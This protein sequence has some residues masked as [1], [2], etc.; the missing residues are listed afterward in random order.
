MLGQTIA[1]Y[2]I[3]EKI[4][5]GGMGVVY[6]AEDQRLHRKTALKFLVPEFL[7]DDRAR[8]RFETEARTIAQLNHPNI[9][10]LYDLQENNGDYFLAME[11]V[12]G[13]T[14]RELLNDWQDNPEQVQSEWTRE[15][16][17][18][19]A[20][21]ICEGLQ[22]AHQHGIIHRDLKPENIIITP[23]GKLKILD[24]GLAKLNSDTVD[25]QPGSGSL[26]Y[27][28]PEQLLEQEATPQTDIWALG[29]ILYELI[30]GQRPFDGLHT[31]GIIYAISNEAP[32]PLESRVGD[33]PGGLN[34]LI[35]HCLEK[36]SSDRPA[37]I[38]QVKEALLSLSSPAG[39]AEIRTPDLQQPLKKHRLKIA[40]TVT[41]LLLGIMI[42]KAI[43]Y[44][45]IPEEKRIA[46]LPF[47][48]VDQTEENRVFGNGLGEYIS[49]ELT[50]WEN[51]EGSL[52]VVPFS[53]VRRL[54]IS[55]AG[56][57]R[58][59][60]GVNLAIGGSVQRSANQT[61]L[62]LNLIDVQ[63]MRQL[64]ST[65]IKDPSGNLAAL[66]SS[67]F[68]RIAEML[69]VELQPRQAVRVEQYTSIA[70]GAYEFYLLGRGYLMDYNRAENLDQAVRL[71]RQAIDKDHNYAAAFAGLGEA[72]WRKYQFSKDT[73]WVDLAVQN[74]QRAIALNS[75][76]VPGLITLGMIYR[77]TGRYREA[78]QTFQ[79]A[80]TIDPQ[81]S[82]AYQELAGA[83]SNLGQPEQVEQTYHKAIRLKPYYWA[84]YYDLGRF[85]YSRGDYSKAEEQF[86]TVISLTPKNYKVYRNLGGIYSLRERYGEA[87]KMLEKSIGIKPNYGAYSNL[88]ALFFIREEYRKAARMFEKALEQNDRYY[89]IWG[90][91]GV[92]YKMLSGGSLRAEKAFR[93]AIELAEAGL[94]VN[95]KDTKALIGLA[96]YHA[97]LQEFQPAEQYLKQALNSAPDDLQLQFRS[98]EIYMLMNKPE[99]A[100]SY[101]EKVLARG[102][103]QK[104]VR[105]SDVFR[106]LLNDPR[107]E[108]LLAKKAN[109]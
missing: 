31:P 68:Q 69:S 3:I 101:L 103:S 62:T 75:Q 89:R 20:M 107:F 29:V 2:R 72:Y 24:L 35:R 61:I 48:D 1:H 44:N 41:A 25:E 28:A 51:P 16:I 70:P 86:L 90:N 43:V 77:G 93:K 7:Q 87:Q 53:E 13:P 58:E 97:N 34:T 4:A 18:G 37:N 104:L 27:M 82:Q 23:A 65:V 100:L 54:K 33:I 88:G 38:E 57:A 66:Q 9:V 94:R 17:T 36:R 105:Q 67:I 98:A 73:S 79:K 30:S 46:V 14:L 64:R 15:R 106:K 55:S 108:N 99:I 80:L 96:N 40:I 95:P 83:Y 85:Y 84:N 39:S 74:S 59:H 56:E 52:W 21:Q 5:E 102:Y 50:R 78:V 22:E 32:P 6:L 76:M 91:L 8:Q 63:Q 60:L 71:F 109:N 47:V 11:Y 10:T 19:I 26:Y 45:S 42:W 12:P 49:S 81:N 92:C